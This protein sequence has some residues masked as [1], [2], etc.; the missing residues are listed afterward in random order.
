VVV[1]RAKGR[2][3]TAAG[4]TRVNETGSGVLISGS[5]PSAGA[6]MRERIASSVAPGRHPG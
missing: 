1:V 2:D 3:V 4:V 6:E 5:L